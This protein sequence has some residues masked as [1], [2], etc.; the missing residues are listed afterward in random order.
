MT[1]MKIDIATKGA[2]IGQIING[3]VSRRSNLSVPE[4]R[5]A[6]RRSNL[7]VPEFRKVSRR[8][9][10]SVPEFRKVSRRSNLPVPEFRKA[11]RRSN[12]SENYKININPLNKKY[13]EKKFCTY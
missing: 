4:F 7:S 13:Y 5:K 9:N 2:K 1:T 6:S 12:L 8:S 3:K 11:S 10:L